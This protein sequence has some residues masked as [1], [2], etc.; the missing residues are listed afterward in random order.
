MNERFT[1]E[2]AVSLVEQLGC[3][4]DTEYGGAYALSFAEIH[5]LLN[6]AAIAK[7]KEW[8]RQEPVAV[9]DSRIPGNVRWGEWSAYPDGTKLYTHTLPVQPDVNAEL[10]VDVCGHY[11]AALIAALPN[12]GRGEAF[13][14]WNEA[15][16]LLAK[17]SHAAQP[18]KS[19]E[20]T[21]PNAWFDGYNAAVKDAINKGV[22]ADGKHVGFLAKSSADSVGEYYLV[23]FSATPESTAQAAPKDELGDLRSALWL[24]DEALKTCRVEAP[25]TRFKEKN[26]SESAVARAL[27]AI[28]ALLAAP[29]PQKKK[30]G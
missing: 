25:G 10:L 2:E 29:Q 9:V 27:A 3:E 23:Q 5:S 22:Y 4:K 15:R 16:K 11:E 21:A 13:V 7:L 1:R 26:F 20:T 24:S 19:A 18:E 17:R 30:E 28:N 12:G 6:A 8:R 14:Q